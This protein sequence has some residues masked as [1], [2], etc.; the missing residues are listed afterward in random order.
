[1]RTSNNRFQRDA[2]LA[3]AARAVWRRPGLSRADFA[4]ELGLHRSTAG[5]LIGALLESGLLVE[6]EPGESAPRGGR[7]PVAIDFDRRFGLVAGLDLTPGS[8]RGALVDLRGDLVERFAAPGHAPGA[9]I[10]E[11]ARAA[12]A[13]A[14]TRAAARALPL[15]GACAA[16]PGIVDPVEGTVLR[17]RPFGLRD[18]PLARELAPDTRFP[19]IVEND[20]NACAWARLANARTEPGSDFVCVL[21]RGNGTSPDGPL[22]APGAGLGI[23]LGGRVHYGSLY[24]A[25]E[26]ADADGRAPGDFPD[27]GSVDSFAGF[28]ERVFRSLVPVLAALA[29]RA[30]FACGEFRRREA[31]TRAALEARFPAFGGILAA[32]GAAFVFA[33]DGGHDVAEGACAT[34][35]SRLFAVPELSGPGA[36]LPIGWDRVLRARAEGA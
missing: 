29:P 24:A 19:F 23:A 17:S 35:L 11:L 14:R 33:G 15:V 20:A 25:G 10:T 31:E 9:A 3:V 28:T 30:V 16:V 6:G 36:R 1:M 18:Y 32:H 12:L 22:T 27:A 5:S 13:E 21:A 7:R 8:W 4:R 2:N 34:F 26:I